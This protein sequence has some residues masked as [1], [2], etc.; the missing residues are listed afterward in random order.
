MTKQRLCAF[1][2]LLGLLPLVAACSDKGDSI[3]SNPWVGKTYLLDVAPEAW[4][5]PPDI[6]QEIGQFVPQF[7]LS[8][9]GATGDN[10]DV[11]V[12]TADAGTQQACNP[13]KSVQ[14]VSAGVPEVQI[15]PFDFPIYLRDEERN[16]T[17]NATVR[18][19]TFKNVLPNGDTA[20]DEGELSASMD[21]RDICPLV[22]GVISPT[23]D[24]VCTAM[25]GLG[26]PCGP[27]SNDGESYCLQIK[28]MYLGAT[29]SDT[30]VQPIEAGSVDASCQDTD[31][32]TCQQ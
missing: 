22:H 20:A 31:P 24:S 27:C 6:G 9:Q 4:S 23:P 26:A 7:L 5:D 25:G 3:E 29:E 18:E 8:V 12:G 2:S 32:G 17:V 10:L 30:M 16:V 13:T 28:A 11:V 21:T 15:G 14:G 1:S 19:L